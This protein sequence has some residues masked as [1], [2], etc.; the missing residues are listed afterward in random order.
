[1]SRNVLV[2]GRTGNGKSTL[3]NL[4]ANADVCSVGGLASSTTR[5]CQLV[6]ITVDGTTYTLVDTIGIG[7]TALDEA[8]VLHR[9][10]TAVHA[11]RDGIVQ[12]S[13]RGAI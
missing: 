3:I 4:L 12:V 2:V 13:G 10:A 9:L 6:P 5:D 7:D 1:M 11:C 8:D